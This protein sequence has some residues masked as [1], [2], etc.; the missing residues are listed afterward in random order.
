LLAG[1]QIAETGHMP[2][3]LGSLKLIPTAS[4]G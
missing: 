3:S 4:G 1:K 2:L